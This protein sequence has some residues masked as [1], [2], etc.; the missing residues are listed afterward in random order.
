MLKYQLAK[1]WRGK[2]K[3]EI[4]KVNNHLS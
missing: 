3:N 2:N 4:I 1:K